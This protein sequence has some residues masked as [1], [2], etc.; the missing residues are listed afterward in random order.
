MEQGGEQV[1]VCFLP[2]RSMCSTVRVTRLMGVGDKVHFGGHKGLIAPS[3][4]Q[5]PLD[6]RASMALMSERQTKECSSISVHFST[7][8]VG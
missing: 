5:D 2:M 3:T 1:L 6:V 4:D 8:A 7:G